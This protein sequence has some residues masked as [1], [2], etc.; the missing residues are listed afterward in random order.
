MTS[1]GEVSDPRCVSILARD[2]GNNS[3]YNCSAELVM[4][5]TDSRKIPVNQYEPLRVMPSC[6]EF[7]AS[8]PSHLAG[9]FQ[10][11]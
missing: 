4:I 8:I 11:S 3:G 6:R 1:M 10:E 2:L 7:L 5:R 9:P